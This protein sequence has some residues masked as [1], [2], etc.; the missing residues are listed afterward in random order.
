[1]TGL[2]FQMQFFR[3]VLGSITSFYEH[4]SVILYSVHV[5]WRDGAFK[6]HLASFQSGKTQKKERL[7]DLQCAQ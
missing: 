2:D 7:I 6:L 5:R 1:M 3:D 4:V